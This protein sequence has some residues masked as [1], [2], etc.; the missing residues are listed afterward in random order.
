MVVS[1]QEMENV[2]KFL[3]ERP[4]HTRNFLGRNGSDSGGTRSGETRRHRRKR[5]KTSHASRM[6]NKSN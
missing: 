1:P 2:F 4:G 5:R 3:G 6:R